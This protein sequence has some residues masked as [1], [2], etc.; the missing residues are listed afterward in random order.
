MLHSNKLR[1]QTLKESKNIKIHIRHEIRPFQQSESKHQELLKAK[2]FRHKNE[3]Q[4]LVNSNCNHLLPGNS[5]LQVCMCFM[6]PWGLRDPWQPLIRFGDV[7][8]FPIRS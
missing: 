2:L 7:S 4:E 1:S 3:K 5:L 6:M 8:T